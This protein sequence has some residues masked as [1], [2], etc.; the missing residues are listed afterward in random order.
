MLD[1]YQTPKVGI[2]LI[3][4]AFAGVGVIALVHNVVLLVVGALLLGLGLGAELQVAAYFA[5]RLFGMKNFGSLY[6]LIFGPFII[7][8]AVGGLTMG[9]IRDHFGSYDYGVMASEIA[10]LL[11]CLCFFV[12]PP[13]VY[14]RAAQ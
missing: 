13:Y 12:L 4:F 14:K 3:L 9:W 8:N 7:G 2:V 10:F 6:S 1:R 5:S 11:A